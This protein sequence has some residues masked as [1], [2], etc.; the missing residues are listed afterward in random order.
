MFAL[1]VLVNSKIN[2]T[3]D[4]FSIFDYTSFHWFSDGDASAMP[5]ICFYVSVAFKFGSSMPRMLE[6]M[7]NI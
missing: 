5:L 2:Y 7:C 1:V 6:I 3:N 4:Y